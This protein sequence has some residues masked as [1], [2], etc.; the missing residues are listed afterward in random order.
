MNL[1]TNCFYNTG[2]I[3]YNWRDSTGCRN[4]TSFRY[5]GLRDTSQKRT[6]K[7]TSISNSF[8]LEGMKIED[9]AISAG[10]L[11]PSC[12][13]Q[14]SGICKT[15]V[16]TK[17]PKKQR[18]SQPKLINHQTSDIKQFHKD[19]KKK[20]REERRRVRQERRRRR[21]QQQRQQKLRERLRVDPDD[22]VVMQLRSGSSEPRRKSLPPQM[23]FKPSI[24][25]EEEEEE[26]TQNADSVTPMSSKLILDTARTPKQ[27]P[28]GRLMTSKP[29]LSQRR[30]RK[31][32]SKQK[33]INDDIKNEDEEK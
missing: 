5:N 16:D 12:D 28:E 14:D 1:S 15:N 3:I 33:R 17:E 4:V 18:K 19:Q 10:R 11:P 9:H 13:V 26:V 20:Q 8:Q 21:K 24:L 2:T 25:S 22:V 7:L 29:K 23:A 30:K 6:E 27:L 31:N 32:S